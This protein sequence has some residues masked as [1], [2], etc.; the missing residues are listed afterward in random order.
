MTNEEKNTA[1]YEKVFAEQETYRKWL[2]EQPPEEIL[3]HSYEY[4]VREDIVLSLEYHDLE[5][6]QAEALL[7]SPAPLGIYSGNLNSGKRTTWIRSLI[8]WSAGQMPL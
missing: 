3:K 5:D 8:L 4:T 1:L 2:L 7:K 6:A